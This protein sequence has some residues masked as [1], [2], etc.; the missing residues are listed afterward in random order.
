MGPI[1]I[2]DWE[3]SSHCHIYH[4]HLHTC[5]KK[6]HSNTTRP[7]SKTPELIIKKVHQS[8]NV[9]LKPSALFQPDKKESV[10]CEV[11]EGQSQ[12]VRTFPLTVSGLEAVSVS[13][14]ASCSTL[15]LNLHYFSVLAD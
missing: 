13:A 15:E 5:P 4:K 10:P 7:I 6:Y 9:I 1:N 3:N 14:F 2:M 8:I 11:S 12:S